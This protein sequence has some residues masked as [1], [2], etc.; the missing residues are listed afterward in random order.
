MKNKRFIDDPG[1]IVVDPGSEKQKLLDQIMRLKDLKKYRAA[2]IAFNAGDLT[3]V[4]AILSN[5]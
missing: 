4:K 1:M 5:E 2:I 3:A